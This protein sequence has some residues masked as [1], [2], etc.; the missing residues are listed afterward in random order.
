MNVNELERPVDDISSF[1]LN[2]ELK[3]LTTS[4]VVN[5]NS[6]GN[7]KGIHSLWNGEKLLIQ[8]YGVYK[9]SWGFY[10]NSIN[11]FYKD[12]RTELALMINNEK[13][14]EKAEITKETPSFHA[15]KSSHKT[16]TLLL[17][18]NQIVSL[19]AEILNI[20]NLSMK[21]VYLKV[22]K[23]GSEGDNEF[24]YEN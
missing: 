10:Q 12:F 15:I 13:L 21:N 18:E 7:D 16:L 22:E 24:G 6:K 20:E 1:N 3:E 8:V 23:L 5:F 4:G 11:T 19:N 2:V 9:I 14:V 17:R